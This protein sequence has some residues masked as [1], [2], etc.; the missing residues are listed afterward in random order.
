MYC[1]K[2]GK[3][4]GSD[5]DFCTNCGSKKI[6]NTKNKNDKFDLPEERESKKVAIGHK[7]II[8]E[9]ENNKYKGIEGWLTLVGLGLLVTPFII[10]FGIFSI[11]WSNF[12]QY[13]S[14][15]Q[16]WI[17][18]E[19]IGNFIVAGFSI[20]LLVLMIK[21]KKQF[22]LYYIFWLIFNIIF[23][24]V[25]YIVSYSILSGYLSASDVSTTLTEAVS[26]LGRTVA[27]GAVWIPYMLVSKRVKA[28]FVK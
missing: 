16:I 7:S 14:D 28:T 8:H 23:L 4:M 26:Q 18:I 25:D 9:N 11:D 6:S 17:V 21:T 24:L 3:E 2:C 1:Y 27:A 10:L 12:S 15:L 22:P 5:Q 19:Q 20:Y 13:S